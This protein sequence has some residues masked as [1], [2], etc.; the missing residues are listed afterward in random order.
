M[1]LSD[2]EIRL[3]PNELVQHLK[4]ASKNFTRKDIIKFIEDKGIKMLNFRYVAE[5][6]K[7]KV[8]NFVI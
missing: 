6:G 2:Q 8:L 5:D 4:K 1:Y 7:L 3:N